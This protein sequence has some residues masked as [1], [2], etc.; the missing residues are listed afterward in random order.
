MILLKN[1][2]KKVQLINNKQFNKQKTSLLILLNKN[3]AQFI[4]Q[5]QRTN[6]KNEMFSK[7]KLILL[8]QI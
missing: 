4:K 2:L 3:S 8:F 1:K 7:P 5:N 6:Q